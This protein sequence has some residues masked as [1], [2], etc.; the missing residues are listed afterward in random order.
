MKIAIA[1]EENNYSSQTDR[2]FGRAAYFILI[3]TE[4]NDY[5]IIENEKQKM[6]LQELDLK[7]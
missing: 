7:Q 3:N 5:E 6:K 1:L 4:T 2:R